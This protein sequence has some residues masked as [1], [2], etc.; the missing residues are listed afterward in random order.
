MTISENAL[1]GK[2]LAGKYRLL[3]PLSKGGMGWIYLAEHVGLRDLRAIK[4]IQIDPMREEFARKRFL[5]E[6]RATHLVSKQNEHVVHIYD[7]YGFENDLG[8][9]VMEYLEG[10]L[11][12]EHIM[13]QPGSLPLV[14]I[15][16]IVV[17]V[18]DAMASIHS[19]GVI[20]RD[21]KPDN[22]FLIE[23]RG[24]PDFVKVVDFGIAK[25]KGS[26]T[27]I[28]EFG[29]ITGTLSYISPEQIT[30]PLSVAHKRGE[31]YIDG[32][33]DIYALGCI[34]FEM[35]SGR[36][37]FL[38]EDP[39][40]LQAKH[41]L[42]LDHVKKPVPLLR[43]FR[44]SV[45]QDLEMV[46]QCALAK[47]PED[48]F[49]SME[50][51]RQALLAIIEAEEQLDRTKT[52]HR[53]TANNGSRDEAI[54]HS[55]DHSASTQI[56]PANHRA[57]LEAMKKSAQS[58]ANPD[59]SNHESPYAVAQIEPTP[60][61]E[62][63]SELDEISQTATRPMPNYGDNEE[64]TAHTPF[65]EDCSSPT[66]ISSSGYDKHELSAAYIAPSYIE[67]E[68]PITRTTSYSV[69]PEPSRTH[70]P[71]YTVV[72][73]R[74]SHC[75]EPEPSRTHTPSY[76]VVDERSSYI[77]PE[78]RVSEYFESDDHSGQSTQIMP[79]FSELPEYVATDITRDNGV[80]DYARPEF[81]LICSPVAQGEYVHNDAKNDALDSKY[82]LEDFHNDQRPTSAIASPW[83]LDTSPKF[84]DKHAKE[85]PA[86]QQNI[87]TDPR[88]TQNTRIYLAL[89][90]LCLAIVLL[91]VGMRSALFKTELC[92]TNM[93]YIPAGEFYFGSDISDLERSPVEAV[94]QKVATSAYCIDRYEYP[95]TMRESRINVSLKEA[96]KI[97][98]KKGKRLCSEQ[99][100]ER[101]CKG[102]KQT[103]YPYGNQFMADNCNTRD[104]NNQNRKI[105][106]SGSFAN[107]LNEYG[108]YDMSGNVAEWTATPFSPNSSRQVVRGGSA[109]RPDWDVRCSS[110]SSANPQTRS[111]T[112]GF[113]CCANPKQ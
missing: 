85:C 90:V 88:K 71:S 5:R 46:V 109:H 102:I 14:W 83:L 106:P 32:R 35:I 74:P 99:E 95:G 101:A 96:A 89:L 113:R 37:P 45:S 54:P 42:L 17:Q 25:I 27:R 41:K 24:H 34:M 65:A 6:I 87:R 86:F 38:L 58:A 63:N 60:Y 77:Q 43:Q 52:L 7:D 23:H 20:H 75:G 73:E 8:Y 10:K 26:Q 80:F 19:G 29:K 66:L 13:N 104:Q 68:L 39:H 11:L 55:F 62:D 76:T 91:F 57:R 30:G 82:N 92:P 84:I 79:S 56:I 112:L 67:S 16:D 15:L 100:W 53:T 28:T 4:L 3:R 61:I 2:M 93:T 47:L 78:Y 110:R 69:E 81:S 103:R 31:E 98:A 70:T 48:R 33:A 1:N 12:S 9:Y 111:P 44:A 49:P 21:L 22:I 72:D 50:S 36:P 107:C 64:S 105:A 108:V 97:C 59:F 18:C 94:K 51:F 40:S